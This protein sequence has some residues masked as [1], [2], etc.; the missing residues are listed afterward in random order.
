MLQYARS[1]LP[2]V[3]TLLVLGSMILFAGA[4]EAQMC[5]FA[6]G[7]QQF[8]ANIGG[9][10]PP[11]PP[12]PHNWQ[13]LPGI[14]GFFTAWYP[15]CGN[16]PY[17][18][19]DGNPDHHDFSATQHAVDI[20]AGQCNTCPDVYYFDNS[21]SVDVSAIYFPNSCGGGRG[22]G[23]RVELTLTSLDPPGVVQGTVAYLHL[24]NAIQTGTP[25]TNGSRIGTV[26]PL[27][28]PA[29]PTFTCWTGP[30]LHQGIDNDGSGAVIGHYTGVYA[31]GANCEGYPHPESP[32]FDPAVPQ[33]QAATG[34]PCYSLSW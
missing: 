10:P 23:E 17:C 11:P 30:H 28:P 4:S 20:G 16:P 27:S 15:P 1:R 25:V 5:C 33:Q 24:I 12:P 8:C 21:G 2:K 19:G 34:V 22:G 13:L 32:P 31:S 6:I 9:P 14:T 7:G 29:D 18:E 3:A 26:H